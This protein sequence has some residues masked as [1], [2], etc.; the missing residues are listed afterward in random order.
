MNSKFTSELRSELNYNCENLWV[1]LNL[2]GAKSVLIGTYYRPH[3]SDPGSIASFE[4]LKKSLT[5]VNQTNSTVWLRGDFNLHKVDWEN[6]IP[7]SDRGHSTF[8]ME[9]HE[10]LDDCLLEQMVILPT[11]G[12]N[13]LDLFLTTNHTFADN[14]SITPGLSDHG[15][16]LTQVNVKPEVLKQ[17]PRNIHLYKKADWDQLKQSMRDVFIE[18]KQS[19][20]A[21][22][23]VQSIWDTFANELDQGIDKFIPIRKAGTRDGFP[24]INQ[25]ICRLMRKRDKLFKHWSRSGR[26][27][28]QSR[29]LEYKHL[30]RRVSDRAYEKYLGNILGLNND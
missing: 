24:L 11:W 16:V 26:P 14:V 10:V 19:D 27:Y 13:I 4:E 21:T 22:T 17:V 23:T 28:D 18:L 5:L 3:K 6:L 1:Q 20:L 7:S 30:V 9:C 12:Q 25:E 29:F 2:A 8:Y 15:I